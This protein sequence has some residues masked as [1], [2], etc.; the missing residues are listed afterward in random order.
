MVPLS[1]TITATRSDSAYSLI[2]GAC[3]TE[4]AKLGF[5]DASKTPKG[6]L[7]SPGLKRN[8]FPPVPHPGLTSPLTGD[9]CSPS[10]GHGS[11]VQLL[12]GATK[13]TQLRLSPNSRMGPQA[14]CL[15][16]ETHS[17]FPRNHQNRNSGHKIICQLDISGQMENIAGFKVLAR[18]EEMHRK[19]YECL[20][21]SVPLGSPGLVL[22]P[23]QF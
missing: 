12:R 21:S 22:F 2:P 1:G 14:T 6:I 7:S 20:Q 13:N 18:Q 4:Q 10:S 9:T 17:V 11:G 3:R 19:E 16:A 23:V 5:F 15:R 8:A